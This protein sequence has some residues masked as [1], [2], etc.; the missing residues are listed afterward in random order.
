MTNIPVVDDSGKFHGTTFTLAPRTHKQRIWF[1]F[2][3]QSTTSTLT[4]PFSLNILGS[5]QMM[6]RHTCTLKL[7]TTDFNKYTTLWLYSFQWLATTQ[8]KALDNFHRSYPLSF[9]CKRV[10]YNFRLKVVWV[11]RCT[12]F[13]IGQSVFRHGGRSYKLRWL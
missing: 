9:H 1:S 8:Y 11:F 4:S 12:C 10:V 6:N 2:N 3:P 5:W 7:P 13:D